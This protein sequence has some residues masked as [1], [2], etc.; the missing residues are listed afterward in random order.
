M[1]Y[2]VVQ[3]G[4]MTDVVTSAFSEI[5]ISSSINTTTAGTGSLARQVSPA[6]PVIV[7]VTIL[8]ILTVFNL[9]GNGFTLITIRLTPRLWTKTNFILAS[10]LVSDIM[11]GVF[12]SWYLP[13]LLVAY[14]FNNPCRFNVFVPLTTT[15]F[16]VPGYSSIYHLILISIERYI[17]IVYPLKYETKFTDRTLKLA[18]SAVWGVGILMSITWS[19]WLINADLRKCDLIH[20]S[21][22]LI[23]VVLAYI[24][25]CVSMFFVYGKILAIWWRQRRRVDPVNTN[26]TRGTSGQATASTTLPTI[27]SSKADNTQ[28]AKE[29]PHESAGPSSEPAVTSVT[30]SAD[31]AEQQRQKIKSRRREFKAVYLTGAIVG[32]FVILWFPNI[33]GRVLAATSYNPVVYNYLFLVGGALGSANFAFSWVIYAAVSKSYRRAYRQLLI[34]IGCCCCKNINA[35]GDNSLIL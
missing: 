18:L 8:L 24:P 10:M 20:N 16:R 28:D 30:A 21:Y 13:F 11:T 33:L 22:Y 1:L 34:R 19:M 9:G 35:Q 14:V 27:E 4:K 23:D 26:L 5:N 17:A 3:N 31:V 15:V 32:Q 7:R 2:S 12:M 29:N 25:V 6:N